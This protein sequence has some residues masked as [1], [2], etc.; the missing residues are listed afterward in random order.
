MNENGEEEEMA[1]CIGVPA[2]KPVATLFAALFIL[3]SV[4]HM[5]I[6]CSEKF[7]TKDVKW[8]PDGKGFILYD[9]AQFC[10][11]FEVEDEGMGAT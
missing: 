3:I 9:K 7:E 1:E 8:A 4:L 11:A 10:C 2:R 5:L 6:L